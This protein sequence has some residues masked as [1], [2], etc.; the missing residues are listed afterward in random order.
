MYLEVL[1]N[2]GR[3]GLYFWNLTNRKNGTAHTFT[4]FALSGFTVKQ[5][6][7]NGPLLLLDV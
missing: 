6:T 4:G 7:S 1:K 3:H 2:C 5:A